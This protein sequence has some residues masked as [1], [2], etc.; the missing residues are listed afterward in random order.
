MAAIGPDAVTTAATTSRLHAKYGQT[1]DRESAY[2][3]LTAKIAT[4]PT[5]SPGVPA[6]EHP[7]REEPALLEKVF[8]SPVVRSFLRSAASTLGREITH[9]MFGTRRRR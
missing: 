9:G 2:E 1:V 4:G 7:Q 5:R 3:Q 6:Q 8:D